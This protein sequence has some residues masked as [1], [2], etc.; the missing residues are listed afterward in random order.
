MKVRG[1]LLQSFLRWSFPCSGR[2]GNEE[3]E[4]RAEVW[5]ESGLRQPPG[6]MLALHDFD[7][8]GKDPHQ[9]LWR[10][11]P[12]SATPIHQQHAGNAVRFAALLF[13]AMPLILFVTLTDR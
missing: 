12:S 11:S 10:C 7:P 3:L 13:P 2:E 8:V 5:E 1:S 9:Q 6:R 4:K